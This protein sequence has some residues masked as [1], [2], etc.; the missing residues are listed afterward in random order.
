MR[1]KL[2]FLPI[3]ALILMAGCQAYEIDM[4]LESDGSGSRDAALLILDPD[5][6]EE[7]IDIDTFRKLYCLEGG[8][9]WRFES[10]KDGEKGMW[11]KFGALVREKEVKRLRDWKKQ[12]G[13]VHI[14]GSLQR[15][16]YGKIDFS[17]ELTVERRGDRLIYREV[18]RWKGLGDLMLDILSDGF[19]GDLDEDYPFLDRSDLRELRG[20]SKGMLSGA[21]REAM[22]EDR[23]EEWEL[24]QEKILFQLAHPVLDR[25]DEMKDTA[26][27]TRACRRSITDADDRWEE[28]LREHYP[29]AYLSTLCILSLDLDLPGPALDTNGELGED[30]LLH[31]EFS[32]FDA[33]MEPVELYAECRAED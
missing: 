2:T 33:L 9:G 29:G 8:D 25:H 24:A 16:P 23:N 15:G 19:V 30:G 7:D 32:P 12:S 17:N 21:L 27:L 31:W 14:R 28:Y 4:K 1:R 6:F 11:H 10:E 26:G 13:D 5:I 22:A 20:L 3:L 18:F